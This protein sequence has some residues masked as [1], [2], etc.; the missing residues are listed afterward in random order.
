MSQ[1]LLPSPTTAS[2]ACGHLSATFMP[3]PHLYPLAPPPLDHILGD[4]AHSTALNKCV[5][6][7]S[8]IPIST[9]LSPL[10]SGLGYLGAYMKYP[11]KTF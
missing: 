2:H 7:E 10:G 1:F 5:R 6:N 4:F 8:Q 11:K 3:S 9:L